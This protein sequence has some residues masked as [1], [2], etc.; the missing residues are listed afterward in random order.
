MYVTL[1]P[2]VT[3][4]AV[5]MV[6]TSGQSVERKWKIKVTQIPCGV[7]YAGYFFIFYLFFFFLRDFIFKKTSF[8]KLQYLKQKQYYILLSL[9]VISVFLSFKVI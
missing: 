6:I 1:G 8:E 2:G 4:P 9:L 7:T 5:L 3:T